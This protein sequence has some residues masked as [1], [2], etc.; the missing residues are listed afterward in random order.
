MKPTT[1]SLLTAL[2]LLTGC[3]TPPVT[4]S[5][6]PGQLVGVWKV[7]LRPDPAAEGYYQEFVVTAVQGKSFSGTFYG[8]PI[9]QGMNQHRLGCGSHCVRHGRWLG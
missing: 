5:P 3:T 9:S 2:V 4:S 6:E 7:D 8:A 1:A